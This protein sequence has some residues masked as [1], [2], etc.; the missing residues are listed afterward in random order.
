MEGHAEGAASVG[1]VQGVIKAYDPVTRTGSVIRD[2]DLAELELAADALTGSV[3]RMVRQGQ[4]VNFTAN[5]AGE[6]TGV[7]FGSE[8]DMHTPGVPMPPG[9]PT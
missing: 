8:V 6:A 1:A 7:C 4:R 3:M 9:D 5:A 2:T